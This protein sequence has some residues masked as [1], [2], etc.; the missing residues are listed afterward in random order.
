MNDLII[1]SFPLAMVLLSLAIMPLICP[2]FWHRLEISALFGIAAISVVLTFSLIHNAFP[3]FKHV[4]TEDYVPFIIMLFTLYTLSHGIHINIKAQ[5]S[6]VN[7]VIFLGVCSF[8]ASVIG[9][10]GA[11]M[12]FL[13]PFIAMNNSRKNKAH[14]IIFF[15][16]LV[17]NIG[18]LLSPLGDPPLLLGYLHGVD[19]FWCAKNLSGIWVFYVFSC[20]SILYF[21]DHFIMK[22]EK[23]RHLAEALSIHE[24]F[25]IKIT[26]FLNIFLV[27][28]TVFVLFFDF[29]MILKN[30]LLLVF[31]GIS[32]RNHKGPKID[33]APFKEVALTFFVI[34]V[35]IA[36][37]VFKLTQ[38]SGEI[39]KYMSGATSYF[40]ACGT[41]SS[42]LDNAP[43]Y[44]LLFNMAGGKAN[45][46]MFGYP[47]I[48]RAI[49]ISSV[50]M[51][52]MTYIGN[53]PNMMVRS[54][55]IKHGFKMPS[56]LGY[57]LWSFGI[58]LP[59]SL[60]VSM[61]FL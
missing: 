32:L 47:D 15:I 37:V 28:L 58:I 36:P 56:F 50:V 5:P 46:L 26:G 8:F 24:Q 16:F 57:M 14:L 17:A 34:F 25:S 45:E 30:A 22:R 18:G 61:L 29:N 42:F 60:I 53:A 49:S 3:I 38:L 31:C 39:S 11:S 6:T 20:L 55:A 43:S 59:L 41:A 2:S 23:D 7:N 21:I 35:V 13:R 51:G 27:I 54:F 44:F 40:W 19:F 1:L 10:T 33:F 48:L 4:L 9:T 12:L 52:A